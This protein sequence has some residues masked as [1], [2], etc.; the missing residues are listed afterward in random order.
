MLQDGIQYTDD[1]GKIKVSDLFRG[2]LKANWIRFIKN[3]SKFFLRI[4]FRAVGLNYLAP[5]IMG[6]GNTDII[7][8]TGSSSANIFRNRKTKK[9]EVSITGQPKYDKWADVCKLDSN[10]K[11]RLKA[12]MGLNP[13]RKTITFFSTALLPI[14]QDVEA[15]QLQMSEL[16]NVSYL[17]KQ[18]DKT[19]KWQIA[20][21]IHPREDA[22]EYNKFIREKALSNVIL[23]N[24][25]EIVD[26][27]AVTDI[28]FAIFSTVIVESLICSVPVVLT[29][30]QFEGSWVKN[31]TYEAP[32][33]TITHT[34]QMREFLG[35]IIAESQIL[36]NIYHS[37][38][39]FMQMY[40]DTDGSSTQKVLDLIKNVV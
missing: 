18:L 26:L 33:F 35:K 4:G 10:T 3:T 36:E 24:P 1:K 20:L 34:E 5:G 14:L 29:L 22:L 27:F 9:T 40:C 32:I 23:T 11:Q 7:A 19:E 13:V 21:K 12:N 25:E 37:E 6:Q 17:L 16:M 31:F 28:T 2:T 8:A 38:R 30:T 39:D 15:H